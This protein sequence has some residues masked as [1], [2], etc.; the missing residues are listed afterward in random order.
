MRDRL[1]REDVFE[2]F[3]AHSYYRLESAGLPQIGYDTSQHPPP[4]QPSPTTRP[5]PQ[6]SLEPSL[7]YTYV[8]YPFTVTQPTKS[9]QSRQTQHLSRVFQHGTTLQPT[10]SATEGIEPSI[11][12][13]PEA[14]AEQAYNK[15]PVNH[16]GIV[17]P[18]PDQWKTICTFPD[19][20][21]STPSGLDIVGTR[22]ELSTLTNTLQRGLHTGDAAHQLHENG[23]HN[24]YVAYEALQYALCQAFFEAGIP[25]PAPSAEELYHI[26]LSQAYHAE[27]QKLARK[28][29]F[30]LHNRPDLTDATMLTVNAMVPL[31]NAV[32]ERQRMHI[33]G[34][35]PIIQLG[36]L[37]REE[38]LFHTRLIHSTDDDASATAWLLYQDDGSFPINAYTGMWFGLCCQP[39]LDQQAA[40]LRDMQRNIPGRKIGKSPKPKPKRP[41]RSADPA[42]LQKRRKRKVETMN[43]GLSTPKKRKTARQVLALHDELPADVSPYEIFSYPKD[44]LNYNNL[45]RVAIWYSNKDIHDRLNYL[46]IQGNQSI[47]KALSAMTKRI[48]SACKHLAEEHGIPLRIFR[49][50]YDDLRKANGIITR[51]KTEKDDEQIAQ[52]VDA[53]VYAQQIESALAKVRSHSATAGLIVWREIPSAEH[54]SVHTTPGPA[55]TRGATDFS[56]T[57]LYHT[58]WASS[59]GSTEGLNTPTTPDG[60]ESVPLGHEYEDFDHNTF[61]M[62]RPDL[63]VYRC[64]PAPI[65]N[66]NEE[67]VFTDEDYAYDPSDLLHAV[68]K[69]TPETDHS[70]L[71]D[72]NEPY[73][74]QDTGHNDIPQELYMSGAIPTPANDTAMKTNTYGNDTRGGY[75]YLGPLGNDAILNT[76]EAWFDAADPWNDPQYLS[77]WFN[78]P[79]VDTAGYGNYDAI[80]S[81]TATSTASLFEQSDTESWIDIDQSLSEA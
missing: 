20:I 17:V 51:N 14:F 57:P 79:T 7:R 54:G 18:S 1:H 21:A 19:F 35:S 28:Q 46:L 24:V 29:D 71:F 31:I 81:E 66:Y 5:L 60:T 45:L 76:D 80:F 69:Y 25:Y 52:P 44:V 13:T 16:E 59:V 40:R 23:G 50:A 27:C 22:K 78:A 47:S 9:C 32:V 75:G 33:D 3:D 43:D 37:Y 70:Q 2:F 48:T 4:P 67:T 26:H 65:G 49:D 12:S 42:T 74:Y 38:V 10:I 55:Y 39:A 63:H 62:D 11:S 61:Y 53:T 36:I 34:P 73:F 77:D 15:P 72:G 30:D 58:P 8:P 56:D 64:P 6:S 41:S 68:A